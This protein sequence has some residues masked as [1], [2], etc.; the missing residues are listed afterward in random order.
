[1]KIQA[2]FENTQLLFDRMGIVPLLYGSLGLECITGKDLNADDIDIL[3]SEIFMTERWNEFKSVLE[4]EGYT[5][6]DE[7]E[8]TFEKNEVY[9][10]YAKIEE[11]EQF[12][13]ISLD[14]IEIHQK[15]GLKFRLLSLEQYLKVYSASVRDGYRINVR[16][17]KDAEKIAF[18]KECLNDKS[19][20]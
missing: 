14:E 20:E 19:S 12:A 8:H 1:M 15:E 17:K 11:L 5:L 13:R 7:H 6:C 9:Y 16:C 10:S 4:N 3:I 18:I 2:F